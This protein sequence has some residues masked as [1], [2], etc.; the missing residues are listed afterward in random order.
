[1][2]DVRV[3]KVAVVPRSDDGFN[4]DEAHWWTAEAYTGDVS[5]GVRLDPASWRTS[6]GPLPDTTKP[7]GID[8]W[9][10]DAQT[11]VVVYQDDMEVFSRIGTGLFVEGEIMTR[12]EFGEQLGPASCSS[13]TTDR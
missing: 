11:G 4:E 12:D 8:I 9:Y 2:S 3:D 7:F 13:S 10:D 1:M 6:T 5:D